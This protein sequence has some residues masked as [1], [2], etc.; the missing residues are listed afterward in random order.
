MLSGQFHASDR[1]LQRYHGYQQAM[2][3]H[4]LQAL[5]PIEIPRHTYA[6]LSLEHL[7]I[8]RDPSQRPSALFCS[9]DLLALS[10]MRDLRAI[11]LRVPDDVSV[12]GFDG[13]PLGELMDPMLS[14]VAQPSEQI[15]ELALRTLVHAIEEPQDG[16]APAS[17]QLL[18]HTV[19]LGGSVRTFD[20]HS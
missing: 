9:N 18:P 20:F 11:G 6:A 5:T 3:E 7:Q 12:M 19:R 15:G 14:S 13:I 10:V 8:F 16:Q 1:A 2:R 17:T 4:G